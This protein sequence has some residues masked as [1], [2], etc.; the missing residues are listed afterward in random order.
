MCVTQHSSVAGYPLG[1]RSIIKKHVFYNVLEIS[2]VPGREVSHPSG[3]KPTGDMARHIPLQAIE[4]YFW[5]ILSWLWQLIDGS[6]VHYLIV[7]DQGVVAE[8]EDLNDLWLFVFLS[9]SFSRRLA[10]SCTIQ[11]ASVTTC[12]FIQHCLWVWICLWHSGF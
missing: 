10:K 4:D 1:S 7:L 11:S 9:L 8:W 6:I 12:L 2:Q 5:T 3:L